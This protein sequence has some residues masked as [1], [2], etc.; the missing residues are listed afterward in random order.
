MSRESGAISVGT[1]HFNIA[2]THWHH[3]H[4]FLLISLSFAPLV[5]IDCP[6]RMERTT[7]TRRL[8]V[9]ME[10]LLFDTR[11]LQRALFVL[12][13]AITIGKL[14]R[15]VPGNQLYMHL[16]AIE[17]RVS[18]GWTAQVVDDGRPEQ[19]INQWNKN[20]WREKLL[21]VNNSV[22]LIT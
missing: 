4:F 9:G 14:H 18:P 10:I 11:W 1:W 20:Q 15:L 19:E 8:I 6:G 3:L 21:R 16:D 12:E 5:I 17:W 7:G 13:C 2:A 22:S